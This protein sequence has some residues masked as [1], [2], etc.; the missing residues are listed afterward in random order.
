ALERRREPLHL[1]EA[2]RVEQGLS[3]WSLHDHREGTIVGPEP[4]LE[5]APPLELGALVAVERRRR[6]VEAD[7]RGTPRGE[8]GP[9]EEQDADDEAMFECP[10]DDATSHALHG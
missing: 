2:N 7:Q 10:A 4:R 8:G 5:L 3:G 1:G 6:E 9:S